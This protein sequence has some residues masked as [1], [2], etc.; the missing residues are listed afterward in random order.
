[1]YALDRLT[2]RRFRG[3]QNLTLDD[4]GRVN[5]LVGPNNSGKTSILE[6]ISVF[7]RP[8]DLAAWVQA[9][10]LREVPSAGDPFFAG[11]EWFFPHRRL[12]DGHFG[13]SDLAISGTGRFP[14]REVTAAYKP[15]SRIRAKPSAGAGTLDSDLNGHQQSGAHVELKMVGQDGP[16]G[17]SYDLWEDESPKLASH[18]ELL[19]RPVHM[20][21]PSRVESIR[22][23]EF[24]YAAEAGLK[25]QMLELTRAIDP[26]IR[27][28]QI[29]VPRG[30]SP[31]IYIEHSAF[32]LLPLS[33]LGDG[34]RR[35]FSIAVLL[36]PLA[37]G[38]LLIDEIESSLHVSALG[39]LFSWLVQS[40]EV[41]DVQL[42]AT[43]HSL[44]AVDAMI[45]AES[46]KLSSIVGYHLEAPEGMPRVR[47][48]EGDLLRRLRYERGLDVRL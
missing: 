13:G 8:L 30:R 9:A 40:C 21:P 42:F 16:A 11:V 43:T 47:R 3:L 20:L 12:A 31:A 44:E 37:G 24:S 48:L 19:S 39:S 5:L 46:E 26:Q 32:G 33:S 41:L 25:E 17:V 38:V 15:I 1:M 35:G 28:I 45:E 34:I 22:P 36:V 2:I 7:C 10:Y 18:T 14:I 6:A 27:D 4:L 23:R 29:L